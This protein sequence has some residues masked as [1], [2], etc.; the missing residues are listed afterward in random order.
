MGWIRKGREK[1]A[2]PRK[3]ESHS[4]GPSATVNAMVD[5]ESDCTDFDS[6]SSDHRRG[7]ST[8]VAFLFPGDVSL[9]SG[10]VYTCTKQSTY[11]CFMA[12]LTDTKEQNITTLH[13]QPF[14]MSLFL[15][16]FS[17]LLANT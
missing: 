6:I 8:P 17:N 14:F 10:S 12:G 11:M 4:C 5:I 7:Q 9:P 15:F 13:S 1:A 2:I 3:K 16:S